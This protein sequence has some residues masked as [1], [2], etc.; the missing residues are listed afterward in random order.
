MGQP[1]DDATSKQGQWNSVLGNA[2]AGFLTSI[3]AMPDPYDP[4]KSIGR[5][6]VARAM[7]A[8]GYVASTGLAFDKWLSQGRPAYVPRPSLSPPDVFSNIHDLELV[9]TYLHQIPVRAK[10]VSAPELYPYSSAYRRPSVE[11]VATPVLGNPLL[12]LS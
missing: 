8:A 1:L 4:S 11:T 5:P 3:S 10:L 2:L 12:S 9:R 7:V 6:A